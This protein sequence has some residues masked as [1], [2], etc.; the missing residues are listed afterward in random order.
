MSFMYQATIKSD[1]HLNNLNY[2]I[3]VIFSFPLNG[4]VP[5]YLITK[6]GC[7]QLLEM[8]S[9]TYELVFEDYLVFIFVQ[10]Q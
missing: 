7:L 1:K 5:G 3:C 10:N 9:F 4:N 2:I 6:T 8:S